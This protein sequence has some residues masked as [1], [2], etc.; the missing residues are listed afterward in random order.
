MGALIFLVPEGECVMWSRRGGKLTRVDIVDVRPR[1]LL[2]F[3]GGRLIF[4]CMLV[5]VLI[6]RS[7]V[8]RVVAKVENG[9]LNI[10]GCMHCFRCEG[11]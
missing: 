6:R 11:L 8:E 1:L 4:H 7:L 2:T 3:V 5:V 9:I 10:A